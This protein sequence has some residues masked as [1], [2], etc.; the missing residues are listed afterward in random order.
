[1]S[2]VSLYFGYDGPVYVCL[3]MFEV[4]RYYMCTVDQLW[5]LSPGV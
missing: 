2:K 4:S 1:M 5:E 3:Y